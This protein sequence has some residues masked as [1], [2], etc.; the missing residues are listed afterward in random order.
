MLPKSQWRAYVGY[1]EG[2]KA[3]R[4]YNA[5]T[6]NVQTTRNYCFLTPID[7]AP[8]EEITVDMPIL[9][10]GQQTLRESND[11]LLCEGGEEDSDTQ[12]V[13]LQ[14]RTASDLNTDP[15]PEEPCKTRGIRPD[16]KYMNDP[17][18]D[19]EEAGIVEVRDKAFA[20]IHDDDCNSLQEA[21]ASPEW[22]EWKR[23]IETELDQLNRMGTWKLVEKPPGVVLIVNKF[24]FA[25]KRD[26]EGN[27][28]KY[29]ARLVA[30]GCAQRPGYDFLKTHSP[31]V[32]VETIRSLLAVAAKHKLYIHQMDIKGAYL[33]G[34]LKEKVYMKQPKGYDNR[35]GRICLLIKTL[36]GLKQAG[37]EWNHEFDSKMRKRRYARLQSDPCVYVWHVGEDFAI[38]AVWVDDLLIFATTIDLRDKVRTDVVKEWEVTDLGEPQKIISIEITRTPESITISSSKYIESILSKEGHEH[39]NPVSTPLDPNVQLV[40][41]PNGEIGNR[42]NSFAQ[43]LGELQYVANATRPDISYAVLRSWAYAGCIFFIFHLLTKPFPSRDQ[44]HIHLDHMTNHLTSHLTTHMTSH[45]PFQ[46]PAPQSHLS[47]ITCSKV[48]CASPDTLSPDLT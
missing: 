18:P 20:V 24:V 28:Q 47:Y 19:E 45:M 42:S 39:C 9:E 16:Y 46:S 4:F 2:S 35:T 32:R 7:S 43:L 15:D 26:K 30:K 27:L 34:I 1:D 41:N 31:V 13:I 6:K 5:A 14:K 40:P 17:F 22:S 25:K 44:P 33:N 48:T 12:K 23:A 3:I 36:Y 37:R 11:N 10:G 8:P 38:I 29:K 21:K